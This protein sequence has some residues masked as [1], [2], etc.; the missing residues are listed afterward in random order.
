MKHSEYLTLFLIGSNFFRSNL[1]RLIIQREGVTES[2][3]IEYLHRMRVASR[4]LLSGLNTFSDNI[5]P[6]KLKIWKR[7]IKELTKALGKARDLDVQTHFLKNFKLN[8]KDERYKAGIDRLIL[9]LEQS[10]DEKHPD[11]VRAVKKLKK[12][13]LQ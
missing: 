7:D 6:E 11:V 8:L 4:K 5:P 1:N 2:N 12:V 3:E 10:R 9:R 13:S